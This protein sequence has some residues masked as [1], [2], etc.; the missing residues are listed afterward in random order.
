MKIVIATD[1][2]R[3]VSMH[4]GRAAKYAVL[5]VEY[6]VIVARELREK[7]SP[8]AAGQV[9]HEEEPDFAHGTGPVASDRHD[10]MAARSPT[11]RSC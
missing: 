1:D 8:H 5:T 6:G 3:T 10:Q 7:L 9:H 11:A 4:F 2:G